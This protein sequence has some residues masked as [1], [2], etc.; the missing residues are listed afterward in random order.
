VEGYSS[1]QQAGFFRRLV[2]ESPEITKILEIGF[3]AGHSSYVFLHARPDVTVVSFDLGAHAYVRKAKEFIDMKF[4]GRHTLL[5]GDSRSTVPMYASEHPGAAFD[6]IFVDGGHEYD[7]AL[8]DLLNCHAM[9]QPH[10][11]VVMDDMRPWKTWGI[12]PVR[13]WSEAKRTGTLEELQLLQDGVPVNIVRR[14]MAT[15]A[16]AVGRYKSRDAADGCPPQTP[17]ATLGDRPFA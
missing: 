13:A 14:K 5:L 17:A 12:G 4:P 7:V 10:G 16:W 6:L 9:A 1:R 15:A 11:L 2:A 8:A 3:N